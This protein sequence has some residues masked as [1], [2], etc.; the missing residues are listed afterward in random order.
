MTRTNRE[1]YHIFWTDLTC[2]CVRMEKLRVC[3]C[4]LGGGEG[5]GPRGCVC[6]VLGMAASVGVGIAGV[7]LCLCKRFRYVCV[8]LCACVYVCSS[9]V[10][11]VSSSESYMPSLLW[12]KEAPVEKKKRL[13]QWLFG[14]IHAIKTTCSIV[15]L[16]W[17]VLG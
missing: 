17:L 10:V 12:R 4:L 14:L 11:G 13:S 16:T 5:R 9:W 7:G 6:I 2:V 3:V 8:C 1:V 15:K